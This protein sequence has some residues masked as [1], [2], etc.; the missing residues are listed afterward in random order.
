MFVGATDGVTRPLG[1]R[2]RS[3]TADE[4]FRMAHAYADASVTLLESMATSQFPQMYHHAEVAATALVHGFE[5]FLKG[6]LVQAGET[7]SRLRAEL[8]RTILN[9][10]HHSMEP[11]FQQSCTQFPGKTYAFSRRVDDVVAR[12]SSRRTWRRQL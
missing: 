2:D 12:D 7:A 11:L 1:L 4:W 5:L 6:A 8:E 3:P 10:K 9:S